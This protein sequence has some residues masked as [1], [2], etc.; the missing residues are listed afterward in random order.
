[1]GQPAGVTLLHC[2]LWCSCSQ[3]ASQRHTG[4]PESMSWVRFGAPMLTQGDKAHT[5][6]HSPCPQASARWPGRSPRS[7]CGAC[8]SGSLLWKTSLQGRGCSHNPHLWCRSHRTGQG[9][10][11]RTQVSPGSHLSGPNL[12]SLG[13][14]RAWAHKAHQAQGAP[15]TDLAR[16]P[17]AE[18]HKA[19]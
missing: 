4:V 9:R 6:R 14:P 10:G 3:R 11:Q 16:E 7:L 19:W 15:G 5:Q 17:H 2:N 12:Q 8:I 18:Q 13:T 1:M